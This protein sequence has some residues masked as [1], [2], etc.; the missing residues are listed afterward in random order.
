MEVKINKE[1][2]NYTE[3]IYF[4]LSLRQFFFSALGCAISVFVFFTLRGKVSTEILSWICI[5]SVIPCGVLGFVT[6]NGMPSE[7]IIWAIIKSKVLVPK[8]L[9]FRATNFYDELL[10]T[11]EVDKSENIKKTIQTG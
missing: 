3:A 5:I 7:K 4:G 10:K 1:I 9:M 2:R 6:Y 8:K 11:K